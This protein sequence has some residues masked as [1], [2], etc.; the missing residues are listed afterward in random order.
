MYLLADATV[1]A[2]CPSADAFAYIADLETF[3]DWFPGVR[4]VSSTD[5]LPPATVGKRYLETVALPGGRTRRIPLVVCAAAAPHRLVTEGALPLLRPRMV[6]DIS[7]R[8]TDRCT[9]RW[10]MYSRA[11][12]PLLRW[13]VVAAAA[14]VLRR[15]ARRAL[16]TLAGRLD[17]QGSPIRS[18]AQPGCRPEQHSRRGHM[19]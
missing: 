17:D 3:A 10:R 4:S 19:N 1:T 11:G 6:I 15:R 5:A 9:I 12:N 2:P 16:R 7:A 8:G 13:T 14:V 18:P